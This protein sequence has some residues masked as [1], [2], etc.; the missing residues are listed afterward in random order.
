MPTPT[1]RRGEELERAILAAAWSELVEHDWSGFSVPRVAQRAGTGKASV[2]ARWP[3]RAALAVAAAV[4]HAVTDVPRRELVGDLRSDLLALL[5]EYCSFLDGPWGGAFRALASDPRAAEMVFP[6]A[7]SHEPAINAVLDIVADACDRGELT[8]PVTSESVLNLGPALVNDYF[9]RR[10][11]TPPPARLREIVETIWL[12]LL[13]N[14][15]TV[16]SVKN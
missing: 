13:F 5:V 10:G 15:T 11:S 4:H 6:D 8:H 16:T 2:Y 14:V 1:R 3:T 9:L 7:A 12:P